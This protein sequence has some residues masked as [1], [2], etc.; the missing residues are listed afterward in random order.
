MLEKISCRRYCVH[1]YGGQQSIDMLR[2]ISRDVIS[3]RGLVNP[4]EGMRFP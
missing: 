2:N 4:S 3:I 1:E